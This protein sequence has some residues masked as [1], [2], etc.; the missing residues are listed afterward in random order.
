MPSPNSVVSTGDEYWHVELGPIPNKPD[1][2]VQSTGSS[3]AFPTEKAA[4][5]FARVHQA[6]EPNR[7]IRV[8]PPAG[9]TP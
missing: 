7:E 2:H 3:Y 8:V 9:H 4:N 6:K 1:W 5:A